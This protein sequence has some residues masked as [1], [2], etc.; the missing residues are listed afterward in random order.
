MGFEN[1]RLGWHT[2]NFTFSLPNL[3]YYFRWT[4]ALNVVMK[5]FS[6]TQYPLNKVRN[7]TDALM[8]YKM[9]YFK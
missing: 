2:K 3:T 7:I 8:D 6:E 9:Q 5:S 1:A 4:A